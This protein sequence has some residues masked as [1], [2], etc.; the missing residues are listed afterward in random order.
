[1]REEGKEMGAADTRLLQLLLWKRRESGGA[2]NAFLSVYGFNACKDRGG[3][4]SFSL[5]ADNWERE[6]RLPGKGCDLAAAA[7]RLLLLQRNVRMIS[8]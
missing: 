8:E 7:V 6:D 5:A 2:A 3:C 1:M 4:C